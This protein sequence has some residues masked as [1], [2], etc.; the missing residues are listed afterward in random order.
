MTEKEKVYSYLEENR[1]P[2]TKIDH[3]PMHTIEAI[4]EAGIDPD[5]LIAKNLFL[6]NDN[7]KQHYLVTIRGEKN[8]DLKDVRKQIMSS[9]LSF[10]SEE[11]LMKCFGVHQG[12][13]SPLGV[14]ND[15]E[16]HVIV[17]LDKD[18][19]DQPTIGMHPNDN[20]ATVFLAPEDLQNIL[21]SNGN[22]LLLIQI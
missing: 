15:P 20:T 14:L 10:A 3:E 1:I 4:A 7:G 19:L 6:R 18:L 2:Y 16:A 8:A 21:R 9:R 11:R 5:G 17:A 22:Q 13:V 12:S